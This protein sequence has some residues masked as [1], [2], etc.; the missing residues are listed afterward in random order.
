MFNLAQ[1]SKMAQASRVRALCLIR[2]RSR[3]PLRSW[4]TPVLQSVSAVFNSAQKS[5][6]SA[7]MAHPRFPECEHC[8]H[9]FILSL[10]GDQG[11]EREIRLEAGRHLKAVEAG[12][13]PLKAFEVGCRREKKRPRLE[14]GERCHALDSAPQIQ[15]PVAASAQW[16]ATAKTALE[17]AHEGHRQLAAGLRQLSKRARVVTELHEKATTK[18]ANLSGDVADAAIYHGN[19][20]Q[21]MWVGFEVVGGSATNA[22]CPAPTR[23]YQSQTVVAQV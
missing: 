20:V 8:V 16:V 17:S 18:T 11:G 1:K 2:R 10:K 13:R 4:R 7:K 22:G 9:L 14:S 3:R 6:T 15:Y 21:A 12:R 23:P 5:S 19:M